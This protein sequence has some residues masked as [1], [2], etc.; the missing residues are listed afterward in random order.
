MV[1]GMGS[2][3]RI[4]LGEFTERALGWKR[5]SGLSPPALPPK[6]A[7]HGLAHA[8]DLDTIAEA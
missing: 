6:E 3:A 2:L 4:A 1:L 7:K 8:G 5:L